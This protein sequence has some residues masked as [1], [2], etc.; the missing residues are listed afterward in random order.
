M[1]KIYALLFACLP[2][3]GFSQFEINLDTSKGDTVQSAYTDSEIK[4]KMY[5]KNPETNSGALNLK[6]ALVQRM[7]SLFS[8]PSLANPDIPT[9]TPHWTNYVCEG[10]LCYSAEIRNKDFNATLFPGDSV[11]MYTYINMKIDTGSQRSCLLIFDPVDSAGTVQTIC[12]TGRA[13][14]D[15]ASVEEIDEDAVL[16]QNA[17]NPFNTNSVIKYDLKDAGALKIQDLTGKIVREIPLNAGN[18]QVSINQLQS[19]IYFYSLWENGQRLA[20]KR[21]QVIN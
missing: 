21:M 3:I 18:G 5:V 10:I 4:I 2:L 16:S 20:T 8:D 11:E 6:W 14:L 15:P 1:K 12:L 19:G 17:P 13:T 9:A 7:D